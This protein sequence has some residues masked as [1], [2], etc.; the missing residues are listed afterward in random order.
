MAW[1][2]LVSLSISWVES[3]SSMGKLA[4]L[5]E[6]MDEWI[7]NDDPFP[8]SSKQQYSCVYS[9]SL[10]ANFVSVVSPFILCVFAAH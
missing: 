6:R 5:W 3:V 4:Y 2:S 1:V 8:L 7:N 10:G 9:R